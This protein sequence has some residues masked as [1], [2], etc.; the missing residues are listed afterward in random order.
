[1][2]DLKSTSPGPVLHLCRRERRLAE[3]DQLVQNWHMAQLN[4]LSLIE[5]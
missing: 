4:V 5:A 3:H 1:M 2:L